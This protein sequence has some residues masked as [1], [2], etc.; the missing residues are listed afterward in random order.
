MSSDLSVRLKEILSRTFN[1]SEHKQAEIIQ[2]LSK[3]SPGYWVYPGVLKRELQ[4]AIEDSYRILEA[5]SDA[6][7]VE[8]WYEY[9][10][11]NCQHVLGT[12]RQ[13]NELPSSFE[14]DF[15]GSTMNTLEN[16]IKIYKVI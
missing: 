1:Y 13:F 14:C 8:G 4:I 7:L 16:T 10:C 12:V 11:G 3:Y 15:C 2:F 5:L 9:C 6:G